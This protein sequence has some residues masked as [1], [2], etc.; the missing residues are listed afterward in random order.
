MHKHLY[1][2]LLSQNV[3]KFKEI[4]SQL[5]KHEITA[6]VLEPEEYQIINEEAQAWDVYI[7]S[8]AGST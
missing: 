8:Q 7:K 5:S 3:Q 4:E 2:E 6:R 1:E